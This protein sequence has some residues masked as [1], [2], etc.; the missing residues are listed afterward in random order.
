MQGSQVQ[1]GS[2]ER[3]SQAFLPRVSTPQNKSINDPKIG[4]MFVCSKHG[5]IEFFFYAH[6]IGNYEIILYF[7][8]YISHQKCKLES[9]VNGKSSVKS[10]ILA[11]PTLQDIINKF[12]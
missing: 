12:S 7:F 4:T 11:L 8:S 2:L 3:P 1:S 9:S 6:I 10:A 5:T